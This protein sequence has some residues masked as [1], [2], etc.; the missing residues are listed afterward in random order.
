MSTPAQFVKRIF[1][2]VSGVVTSKYFLVFVFAAVWMIFFDRY[3]LIS[4]YKMSHQIK[5]L[6]KDEQHY[7]EAIEKI[8][9]QADQ[10]FSNMDELERYARE[11]Y[12]MRR[13]GEDIYIITDQE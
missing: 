9:Y 3:N 2:R 7:R 8:D 1:S 12:Y 4:Q 11:K 10:L 6:E 13:S 5:M